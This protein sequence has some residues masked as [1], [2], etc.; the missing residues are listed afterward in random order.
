[1]SDQR[2]HLPGAIGVA[3]GDR[4]GRPATR[5]VGRADF[6]AELTRLSV[7]V[8][9]AWIDDLFQLGPP[10]DDGPSLPRGCVPYLPCP[11]DAIVRAVSAASVHAGDVFVDIGSGVGRAV[12]LVHLLTGARGVG[13]EVQPALVAASRALAARLALDGVTF[14]EGDVANL[15]PALAGGS[16]FFLYCPFSG[17]RLDSLLNA[18]ELVA[19]ARPIRICCVDVP[20]PSRG[21]LERVAPSWPDVTVYRSRSGG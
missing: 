4:E 1:M 5:P 10:P 21:W 11:V 18:L 16:V 13:I 17:Q 12:A 8:R 9:D 6:R 15:T 20:L 19:R 3:L 2:S 7:G 14:V